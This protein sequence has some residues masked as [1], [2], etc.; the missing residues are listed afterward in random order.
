[1]DVLRE[2]S[3]RLLADNKRLQKQKVELVNAFKK[4]MQLIDVLK[5]QKMHIEAAKLLQFTEEE[6]IKALNWDE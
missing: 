1:M 3:E 2:R 6:F 4:Q 5:R